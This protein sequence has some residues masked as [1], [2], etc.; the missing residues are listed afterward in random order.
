MAD[1]TD[2][3]VT[4]LWG[5]GSRNQ[6]F[7]RKVARVQEEIAAKDYEYRRHNALQPSTNHLSGYVYTGY[8]QTRT[9]S[10]HRT[11]SAAD[12]TRG[13]QTALA[14]HPLEVNSCG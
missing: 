5:A 8:H 12:E 7:E 3:I 1:T 13:Y 4:S 2:H 14:K 9:T 11:G 10:Q 6:I